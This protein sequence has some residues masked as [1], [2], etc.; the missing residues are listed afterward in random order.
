MPNAISKSKTSEVGT[1]ALTKKSIPVLEIFSNSLCHRNCPLCDKI[2]VRK[3]YPDYQFTPE[4]A[5][6]L[7]E[8]LNEYNCH[9]DRLQFVGGDRRHPEK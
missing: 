1:C 9:I 5:E 8:K 6:R 4:M 3:K 2:S 7:A